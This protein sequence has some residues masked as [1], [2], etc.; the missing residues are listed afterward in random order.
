MEPET[1]SIDRTAPEPIVTPMSVAPLE[2]PITVDPIV[3]SAKVAKAKLGMPGFTMPH[4]DMFSNIVAG[5]EE[6]LRKQAAS[7][8]DFQQS[9]AKQNII[10]EI[11]SKQNRPFSPVEAKT[12][13]D[14]LN[15]KATD[16]KSV[17]EEYYAKQYM[18]NL[19][20][21][22]KDNPDSELNE[23]MILQ[24]EL[25][26]K[27]IEQAVDLKSKMEFAHSLAERVEDV[28]KSKS[29]P[30]AIFNFAK[31]FVPLYNEVNLRSKEG[32]YN[33]LGE[34]MN[35]VANDS[36]FLP[37]DKFKAKN[38]AI[39]DNLLKGVAGGNPFL[40][41]TYIEALTNQTQSGTVIN[42][43]FSTLDLVGVVGKPLQI[44]SRMRQSNLINKAIAD[45]LKAKEVPDPL[46]GF[47]LGRT[48][49]PPQESA[50]NP[51]SMSVGSFL[52]TISKDIE[53]ISRNAPQFTPF[54]F[55]KSFV[56]EKAFENRSMSV[57][58]YLQ[59]VGKRIEEVSA[60]AAGN[61]HQ[62]GV[63]AITRELV[64]KL[65]P[66]GPVTPANRTLVIEAAGEAASNDAIKGLHSAFNAQI[67]K[68]REDPRGLS[69]EYVNRIVES[70]ITTRDNLVNAISTSMK[71]ER[72]PAALAVEKNVRALHEKIKGDYAGQRNSYMNT[73]LRKDPITGGLLSDTYF[74]KNGTEL[75]GT[76][77]TAR[78]WAVNQG[79]KDKS[80]VEQRGAGFVVKVTKAEDETHHVIRDGLLATKEAKTP[81]SVLNAWG[82]YLGGLRTPEETLS[83]EQNLN[84]HVSAYGPGILN[85]MIYDISKDIRQLQ[86]WKN[87]PGTSTRQKWNEWKRIVSESKE[88]KDP[89][90][91]SKG[92]MIDNV[93]DL[94][95]F[96]QN[97][98]KRLPDE[99][100][101][102]AYF[103]Y[104][105]QLAVEQELKNLRIYTEKQR[106][107]A[108]T[109]SISILDPSQ[110]TSRTVKTRQIEVDGTLLKELPNDGEHLWIAGKE[111]GQGRS[112]PATN[113]TS[114]FFKKVQEELHNSDKWKLIK[115]IDPEERP[116]YH[117]G[118]G[119]D[120]VKY[121]LAENVDSKPISWNQINRRSLPDY[122]YDHYVAQG[123]VHTDS[124]TKLTHYFGDRHIAAF[125]IRA[126]SQ[127]VAK[128]LDNIRKFFL[129]EDEAGARAY[130]AT[131]KLPQDFGDIK[132][133]FE[134]GVTT[135][136]L[137][138]P[139]RLSKTEPII[140]VPYN[141]VV[142]DMDKNMDRQY[143]NLQDQT[144]ERFSGKLADERD[145]DYL[146]TLS[147]EGTRQNPIYKDNPLKQIDPIVSMNRSLS[148]VIQESYLNDYKLFSVEHWIQEAKEWLAV[149]D[150]RLRSAPV[151]F[152]HNPIWKQG[153]PEIFKNNMMTAQMQIK[154]FLGVQDKT[155]TYLHAVAQRLSDSIY[156]KYGSTI[157]LANALTLPMVRDPAAFIR[158]AI[159]DSKLGLFALPQVWVQLQTFTNIA[160]IAGM[161]YA[162]PAMRAT[163]LHQWSRFSHDPNILDHLDKLASTGHLPFTKGFKPGEFKEAH[164]LLS[165]SGF[166]HVAGEYAARDNVFGANLMGTGPSNFLSWGRVAFT[167]GERATRTGAFY[168]AYR[169]FR[170]LN[171]TGAIS[172]A[173]ART[174][175]NRADLLTMNMSRASVSNLNKGIM[176]IPTQFLTYSMRTAELFL[177]KRLTV[178]EKMRLFGT[179]ALLYGLPAAFGLTGVPFGEY[180]KKDA[181]EH[182][183]VV[184]E[185]YID[186]LV[187][188]GGLSTLLM[189]LS[190]L[191]TEKGKGNYYNVAERYGNIQG[192][193]VLSD[194]FRSDKTF[195][196]IVGG[197]AGS[198]ISGAIGSMDGYTNAMLSA[199]RDDNKAYTMHVDDFV[200]PFLEIS[201]VSSAYKLAMALNTGKWVSKKEA[202]ISDTSK[203]NAIFMFLSGLS[204]QEQSDMFT[205][206]VT[207]ENEKELQQKAL[208]R[209]TTE[210][211]RFIET[212]KDNP[213][214]AKEYFKNAFAI[215]RIAG[216]PEEKIPA[217]TAIAA[218]GYESMIN[219][220][221]WDYYTKDVSEYRKKAAAEALK[222]VLEQTRGK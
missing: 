31:Y 132:K 197:A 129:A 82:R 165:Q 94:K 162:G 22:M 185:K 7:A 75:F 105:N 19:K 42:N 184:G 16:P 38:E 121:V 56:P 20:Q 182:G 91:G 63:I 170:E 208:A 4:E 119:S 44:I 172:N 152:F 114:K 14:F 54:I 65:V 79:F 66:T 67:Q 219:R 25:F 146:F 147:N 70:M 156:S 167:E 17:F 201:S 160:G 100:E 127:D 72:I 153:T 106:L 123:I 59:D 150:N 183:Y 13:S 140:S 15:T 187:M 128:H 155:D 61:I 151:Y 199:F 131:T 205:K 192:L 173:D 64:K 214:Q 143:P 203:G 104:K 116:F 169:E 130:H 43:I 137:P 97:T 212:H 78:S 134:A 159:F 57:G 102:A 220:T 33:L 157:P 37:F 115:L 81:E 12:I 21:A 2:T 107:G 85:K 53:E 24:P 45:T 29:W 145:P 200:K 194:M 195:W 112:L 18:E 213:E 176:S 27:K 178:E 120:P 96:Y 74:G 90:T 186:S 174:I 99:Q 32:G 39:V 180:L 209:F 41:A 35:K 191:G 177:G 222:T 95:D 30:S 5:R 55:P 101:I 193:Q 163:I 68:F 71:V 3:A 1:L 171:P 124:V 138:I 26:N 9:A 11:A 202:Y 108:Q 113:L 52:D 166:E 93:G 8:I 206:T 210:F 86:G 98:L 60:E 217:A 216:Y 84:R 181:A 51:K 48:Y 83:M 133:W 179:N 77:R 211:R 46:S 40:A 215:L 76:E 218:Q 168:T 196:D 73:E 161:S 47:K 188:E 58:S 88:I 34:N 204:P 36:Y 144:K 126:M 139:P 6:Q 136:G 158:G 89:V 154:Q 109:H 142:R 62:A 148:R 175:L 198:G 49:F 103:T 69:Q 10:N 87:L 23:A 221:N 92:K 141:K 50:F 117:Y 135:E 122:D 110:Q 125:N 190:G 164:A 118:P 111:L 189:H 28:R 80:T 149:D 207:R